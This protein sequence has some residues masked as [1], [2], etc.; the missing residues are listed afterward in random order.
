[1]ELVKIPT[2]NAWMLARVMVKDAADLKNVYAIQDAMEIVPLEA[3]GREYAPPDGK[4]DDKND[5]IP[6]EH[7]L[8]MTPEEFFSKANV[9]MAKNPPAEADKGII[10]RMKSINVGAGLAFNA[11]I[12]GEGGAKRWA[13]MISGL[14]GRLSESS[15]G[16]MS[17]MGTWEFYGEPIAEF[18]TEYG[19][20]AFVALGGLGANPVSVA[21]YPKAAHDDDNR[22]LN[23]EN[24]YIVHFDKVPPVGEYGFWSMT[25]YGE[26]NFLID[27]VLDRY[28]VN[29][30]SDL[31]FNVDGSLDI[32]VQASPPAD[33]A[34]M[35]NW[36]P[37]KPERF[38]LHMRIYLPDDGVFNGQWEMPSIERIA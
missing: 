23:G 29:D 30:R 7:V 8:S 6:V 24:S 27:N 9:L 34:M 31:K 10:E 4:Y 14:E 19:F 12:L 13:E 17:K 5:Y 28:A 3:Y 26:D 38:H 15:A 25:A 35:G 21:I 11:G 22:I 16:F 36:L 18:G 1:M 33:E 32:L 2:N 20:R 37:V